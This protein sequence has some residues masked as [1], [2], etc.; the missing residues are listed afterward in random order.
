MIK[1]NKRLLHG[2]AVVALGLSATAGQAFAQPSAQQAQAPG[3]QAQAPV[4]EEIT[5]TARKVEENLMTVPIAISAVTATQLQDAG[6]KDL[7]SLANYTPGLTFD[8]GTGAL[9]RQ[10]TFRGLSVATGQVFIDGSPYSGGGNLALGNLERVEVLV[11][12]QSVYFGRSTFTGALNYVTKTPGDHFAGDFSAEYSSFNSHDIT[13]SVEG[14][15]IDGKLGVRVSAQHAYKGGQWA[16]YTDPSYKMGA[17]ERTSASVTF[18]GSPSDNINFKVNVIY[19]LENANNTPTIDLIGS[20]PDPDVIKSLT[21]NLGGTFGPYACGALP[22]ANSVD[23]RIIST[24]PTITPFIQDVAWRQFAAN[25]LTI[26]YFP[27]SWKPDG[28]AKTEVIGATGRIDVDVADGWQV[29]V[30]SSYFHSKSQTVSWFNFRDE[31][32]LVR[33]PSFG[34]IPNVLEWISIGPLFG[35]NLISDY[36]NEL[37]LTSPTNLRYRGT[38][39]ASWLLTTSPGSTNNGFVPTVVGTITCC[40]TS[41]RNSTPAV[42]AGAYY[43]ITEALT[44]GA[45]ARYQWD[46][47]RRQPQLSGSPLS[48]TPGT[49]FGSTFTSFSPRVTVDWKYAANSLVYGLWSRGYRPGGFNTALVTSPPA[50]LAQLAQFGAGLTFAQEKLDNYEAGLKST[51]LDGRLQ[52]RLGVYYDQWSNGQVANSF[53]LV[54]T[55]GSID[56]FTLTTNVGAVDMYGVEFSG[57]WAVTRS[58]VLN[59]TVN[60]QTSDIKDYVYTPAG[61]RIRNST[62]VTGNRF[63]NASDWSFTLS[64]VYTDVLFGDWEWYVRGDWKYKGKYFVDPTNVAWI[65]GHSIFDMHFGIK[66]EQVTFEIY[67]TNLLHDSHF[68]NASKTYDDQMCCILTAANGTQTVGPSTVNAIQVGLPDKR[69]FGVKARYKF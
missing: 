21:C 41:Q 13:G 58:L 62:V 15:L 52:T 64:P 26:T 16:S 49:P 10:L 66:N 65:D 33:N 55:G 14:P 39:G 54:G 44:V 40:P 60:Y 29:T 4:F 36:N 6:I 18:A 22:T 61:T 57:N 53:V 24:N 11:G 63:P 8:R 12:P 37:R 56:R 35:Q 2:A 19:N 32:G 9:G 46:K 34:V 45:E 42:F 3:Q 27:R 5:V 17:V 7:A 67:G 25:P 30:N 48:A 51:W 68:A 50:T 1:F 20:N 38:I 43:D 69:A 23:P 59:A 31:R 28:G 47:L